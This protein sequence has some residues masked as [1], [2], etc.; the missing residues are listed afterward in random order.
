MKILKTEY[1]R[2]ATRRTP[3]WQCA[4]PALRRFVCCLALLLI[5]R[6][7]TAA[8]FRDLHVP[9]T[10]PDGTTIEVIGWGDEFHAVFETP[11][12]YTV[13]FDPALK[14]YCFAQQGADG[15]L[16][17]TGVQVHRAQAATLG[18]GQHLRLTAAARKRSAMSAGSA[19][20]PA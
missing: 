13:V 5:C 18:L 10:Q 1:S 9:F 6:A 2:P 17:S 11:D 3:D 4:L 12:G 16:V 15:D 7:S 14:A 8:P 20:R 19:G